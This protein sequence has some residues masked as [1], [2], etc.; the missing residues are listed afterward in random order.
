MFFKGGLSSGLSTVHFVGP[1]VSP[2][3]GVMQTQLANQLR[4]GPFGGAQ[5]MFFA[6]S[7][8]IPA[9]VQCCSA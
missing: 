8:T 6:L 9:S 5:N 1:Q 3:T 2:V 4:L 7:D